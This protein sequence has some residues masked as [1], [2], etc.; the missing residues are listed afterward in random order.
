MSNVVLFLFN[1]NLNCNKRTDFLRTLNMKFHEK[2][3]G[4]TRIGGVRT[5]GLAW[6]G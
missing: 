5:D 1:L 3:S 4:G 6:W 2:L